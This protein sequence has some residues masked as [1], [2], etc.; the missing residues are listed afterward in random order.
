LI[1]NY[2]NNID[3]RTYAR[4]PNTS[5]GDCVEQLLEHVNH[6][7]SEMK[8]HRE[9]TAL[10]EQMQI[11][12]KTMEH[13]SQNM[14]KLWTPDTTVDINVTLQKRDDLRIKIA[15][16]EDVIDQIAHELERD[17][18]IFA[19]LQQQANQIFIT[20]RIQYSR[21]TL[22]KKDVL[23]AVSIYSDLLR[24]HS[25]LQNEGQIP[26]SRI[27]ELFHQLKKQETRVR[28][29]SNHFPE[30]SILLSQAFESNKSS[31]DGVNGTRQ[32]IKSHHLWMDITQELE[33]VK[34]VRIH[35]YLELVQ[36][37]ESTFLRYSIDDYT[38]L[39][40]KKEL[41]IL[42]EYYHPYLP[43]VLQIYLE[44]EYVIAKISNSRQ[45]AYLMVSD[46][47]ST[48]F[49]LLHVVSFLHHIG[50][51]HGNI[52]RDTVLLSENK[53]TLIGMGGPPEADVKA[54]GDILKAFM[55]G[56]KIGY[57]STVS[58]L[59]CQNISADAIIQELDVYRLEGVLPM[60]VEEKNQLVGTYLQV[61]STKSFETLPILA[62]D[63]GNVVEPVISYALSHLNAFTRHHNLCMLLKRESGV[64]AGGITKQVLTMFFEQ[65]LSKRHGLFSLIECGY[66][67]PEDKSAK[68]LRCDATYE[69]IG[70][71]LAY[72]VLKRY[73]MPLFLP[74]WF[75][76]VL[77]DREPHDEEQWMRAC[78]EYNPVLFSGL[79]EA[80]NDPTIV[81][82]TQDDIEEYVLQT[83]KCSFQGRGG[84]SGKWTKCIARGFQD[85]L[86]VYFVQHVLGVF[87]GV[88]LMNW[89]SG[90]LLSWEQ[91]WNCIHWDT[92]WRKSKTK[93]YL[94]MVL[95]KMVKDE[96]EQFLK[97]TTS[98]ARLPP[99]TPPI[100]TMERSSR[101]YSHTC[102]N[103]FELKS[104]CTSFVEFEK[105]FLK[106][107]KWSTNT[108][109]EE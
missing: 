54:I 95:Q 57:L 44:E 55:N 7:E 50:I 105:I 37:P 6:W 62:V 16:E 41:S 12:L 43:K 1:K 19:Q 30:V 92:T 27:T 88:E 23:H 67:L 94:H 65:M 20:P 24:E 38:H 18:R 61:T 101:F 11:Q 21:P 91:I 80:I 53:I 35:D 60:S 64:D 47:R 83:I 74:S 39:D 75:Y 107:L 32:W 97:W 84:Y 89:M 76:E 66:V 93:N 81:D 96:L 46:V 56:R 100:I 10:V 22:Q 72:C 52:S 8:R 48:I 26:E 51:G 99:H 85:M 9:L 14:I 45:D 4:R 29:M 90:T 28:M 108:T 59:L 40:I 98:L 3:T 31:F 34:I 70:R 69:A 103:V 15:L 42:G 77:I 58:N 17:L 86:D 78:N 2:S 82:C 104:D 106:L 25:R 79:Q 109:V 102:S 13:Y 68:G 33:F 87:S 73:T 49:Q 71:I 63:R 36:S 5:F